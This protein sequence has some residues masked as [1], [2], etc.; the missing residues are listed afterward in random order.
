MRVLVVDD[1]PL[2]RTALGNLLVRRADVDGFELA[3]NGSQA[4]EKLR[5]QLY[6]VMLLDIQ[7]PGVSGIEL[8]E[9]LRTLSC[10]TPAVIFVTAHQ[11]HAVAAFEKRALDYIL[12]PFVPTRVHE[13]LDAAIR[14]SSQERAERL[15]HTLEELKAQPPKATTIAIKDKDR[16]VFVNA[17]E[18]VSAEAHG[19][20]VILRGSTGSYLHR[21]TIGGIEERLKNYG[22]IRI[23]PL[24][25]HQRRIR[26]DDPARC[27]ERLHLADEDRRGVSRDPY[28]SAQPWGTRQ[29][30]AG[31]R[32]S[33][34]E[35]SH[36]CA[37]PPQVI[38]G[39]RGFVPNVV[40]LSTAADTA[41]GY[42]APNFRNCA[43]CSLMN[44]ASAGDAPAPAGCPHNEGIGI[45]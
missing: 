28:L 14:R 21:G 10:P 29:P 27:W 7:M 13:A 44:F 32:E 8:I 18:I 40:L 39:L 31:S 17:A 42:P 45:S 19:N 22:F 37:Q 12:K 15:V 9:S 1:E 25:T 4:L 3:E 23:L 5:T 26:R 35:K 36:G 11:E 30:L 24:G 2:A 20:Y 41:V 33:W 6:D 43:T 34:L 16:I 38:W